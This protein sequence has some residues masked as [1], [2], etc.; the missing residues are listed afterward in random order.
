M[1]VQ[2]Q[3]LA[4][5]DAVALQKNQHILQFAILAESGQDLGCF[6]GSDPIHFLQPF[7]F[8]LHNFQRLQPETLD[9]ARRCN[10]T[11]TLN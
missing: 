11:D 10:R 9:D 4:H 5:T 7:R 2:A 3:C 6:L 1:A 8:L